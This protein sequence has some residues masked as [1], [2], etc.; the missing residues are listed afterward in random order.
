MKLII[1]RTLFLLL[2]TSPVLSPAQPPVE[3]RLVKAIANNNLSETTRLLDSSQ[4]NVHTPT[5]N[6][7]SLFQYSM[8]ADSLSIFQLLMSRAGTLKAGDLGAAANIGHNS[9]VFLSVLDRFNSRNLDDYLDGLS[10]LTPLSD[11][12]R[13]MMRMLLSD[14]ASDEY[15]VEE[16]L[17]EADELPRAPVDTNALKMLIKRMELVADKDEVAGLLAGTAVD[18]ELDEPSPGSAYLM[19][20]YVYNNPGFISNGYD[21]NHFVTAFQ[22]GKW[23]LVDLFIQRGARPN[24]G[25][26]NLSW[27]RDPERAIGYFVR[28]QRLE[29]ANNLKALN[30]NRKWKMPAL[31]VLI[32]K[33]N[34][35]GNTVLVPEFKEAYLSI[36]GNS[37]QING[38][39]RQM[40]LS[41]SL[42]VGQMNGAFCVLNLS[43]NYKKSEQYTS[44][45]CEEFRVIIPASDTVSGGEYHSLFI[46]N[47]GEYK[48]SFTIQPAL[49]KVY[50]KG[51]PIATI[52]EGESETV[53]RA[54]GLLE[55]RIRFGSPST[56][57][58]TATF[59][60]RDHAEKV[61]TDVRT[62]L[63]LYKR[64]YILADEAADISD[65]TA[66]SF[67]AR[68][69]RRLISD[70]LHE[71]APAVIRGELRVAMV[72]LAEQSEFTA[73]FAN[74]LYRELLGTDISDALESFLLSQDSVVRQQARAL[75]DA[76][77][78]RTLALALLEEENIQ[79]Y[80]SRLVMVQNLLYELG[81]YYS[82][83]D[84]LYQLNIV[85]N[86]LSPANKQK[87]MRNM[88][89]GSGILS[90][91][92]D[93]LDGKGQVIKD[94]LEQ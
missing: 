75:R 69:A 39:A 33:G 53:N 32:P 21:P 85:L 55:L 90:F 51:I 62:R 43:V 66:S 79:S 49:I 24:L 2:L 40:Q 25:D 78:R 30:A 45:A 4:Y 7:L 37:L 47:T 36:F 15:D 13:R 81:Q 88:N 61:G 3:I 68:T 80:T 46:D 77:N 31:Q 9:V 91:T 64:L 41:G 35:P 86:E 29:P 50:R 94:F 34:S 83:D 57:G 14:P 1:T 74:L 11:S 89:Q 73:R 48:D 60:H 59:G 5:F 93:D 65:G 52:E 54:F 71:S 27:V 23:K 38:L 92:P 6:K 72:S 22:K 58:L 44:G 42:P 18:A 84:L 87:F 70:Q 76:L 8:F 67:D 16:G 56:I 82:R 20:R 10:L 12:A 19:D 63:E 17:E 28:T 26:I